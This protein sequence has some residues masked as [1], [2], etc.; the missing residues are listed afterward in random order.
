MKI[1][2]FSSIRHSHSPSDLFIWNCTIFF[3]RFSY[4]VFGISSCFM[5]MQWTHFIKLHS[6]MVKSCRLDIF[7]P[8]KRNDENHLVFHFLLYYSVSVAIYSAEPTYPDA[9]R[10]TNIFNIKKRQAFISMAF[11][12]FEFD[13]LISFYFFKWWTIRQNREREN[14]GQTKKRRP[15]GR[16]QAEDS[17]A[18]TNIKQNLEK[19]NSHSVKILK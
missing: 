1:V 9:K 14:W 7:V 12:T 4:F 2:E 8:R 17:F 5:L 6:Y 11:I 16:A 15:N 19:I 3:F 13:K 10:K 18:L